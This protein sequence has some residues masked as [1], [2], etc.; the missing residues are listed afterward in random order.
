MPPRAHLFWQWHDEFGNR[1]PAATVEVFE[2]GTTTKIAETIYV[3][4]DPDTGVYPNP[5]TSDANGIAQFFLANAKR[6]D[7]RFSKSGFTTQT[8]KN[9]DVT[10]VANRFLWRTLWVN[11]TAY[12]ANDVVRYNNES[13]IA[14]RAST[15]VT[16][17]EGAD[18]SKMVGAQDLS[19]YQALSG[20]G[21]ANGYAGL[22]A[23]AKVPA[24]QLSQ[25]GSTAS[26]ATEETTTSTTYVDLATVGPA[27]TV[28][29]GVSGIAIVTLYAALKNSDATGTSFMDVGLSGANTRA[30]VDVTALGPV[31]TAYQRLGLSIVLTGLTPGATTFTAKYRTSGAATGT[32]S[33]R[34]IGVVTL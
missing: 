28:T 10:H 18:W 27:V 33:A 5:F 17:V 2:P 8:L 1:V 32:F 21:A 23:D 3:A 30:A 34:R 20:K 29:V 6:V 12:V 11:T 15:G 13:W 9:L 26:V 16:P 14:L 4:D 31:G 19:A 22:N 25:A 7:L 24:A